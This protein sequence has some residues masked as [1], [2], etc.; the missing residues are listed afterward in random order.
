MIPL[1]WALFPNVIPIAEALSGSTYPSFASSFN[2]IGFVKWRTPFTMDKL[3][4]F[5][6]L[7]LNKG[8]WVWSLKHCR[9]VTMFHLFLQILNSYWPSIFFSSYNSAKYLTIA[10]SWQMLGYF[11]S[12]LLCQEVML[13]AYHVCHRC[14]TVF[15]KDYQMYWTSVRIDPVGL[16]QQNKEL[17]PVTPLRPPKK[18]YS[19]CFRY[20]SEEAHTWIKFCWS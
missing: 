13:L 17:S 18:F 11:L 6:A 20:A 2:H 4:D 15:R 9:Q 19:R 1:D 7:L 8:T 12:I 5:L 10:V 14:T 3:Y 16:K